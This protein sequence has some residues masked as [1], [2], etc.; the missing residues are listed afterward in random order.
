ADAR[1][2]KGSGTSV[3][4]GWDGTNDAGGY[5]LNG[6]NRA[7]EGALTLTP[8]FGARG[9]AREATTAPHPT[10]HLRATR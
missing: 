3:N 6:P 8:V 9:T 4:I 5:P 1:T 2:I 10:T 7:P